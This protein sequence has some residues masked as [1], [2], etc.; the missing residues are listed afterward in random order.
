MHAISPDYRNLRPRSTFP[1]ALSP[2]RLQVFLHN[3]NPSR[4]K[5][6]PSPPGKAERSPKS[7][8]LPNSS[9]AS[10]RAPIFVNYPSNLTRCTRYIPA[11]L[12][13]STAV[14][15]RRAHSFRPSLFPIYLPNLIHSRHRIHL[16]STPTRQFRRPSSC[17]AI[18]SGLVQSPLPRIRAHQPSLFLSV[19]CHHFPQIWVYRKFATARLDCAPFPV[20]SI[21]SRHLGYP[22]AVLCSPRFSHGDRVAFSQKSTASHRNY[23]AL[24]ANVPYPGCSSPLSNPTSHRS[25]RLRLLRILR[26]RDPLSAVLNVADSCTRLASTASG[27]L[28]R[29]RPMTIA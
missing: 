9:L 21:N 2:V 8:I 15:S 19:I 29:C 10:G 28:R 24:P 3:R 17:F 1:F 25:I 20:F 11:R 18:P 12:H 26:M 16:V 14:A 27:Y 23:C 22:E 6:A 5:Q 4:P 13:H 7:V